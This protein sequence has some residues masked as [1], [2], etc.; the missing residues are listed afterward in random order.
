MNYYIGV[1]VGTS[2]TKAVLFD[3][4]G[5][6]IT[7][8]SYEYDIIVPKPGYAEQDPKKWLSATIS[9]LNDLSKVVDKNDIKGIGLSGQMHGLVMLD[10]DDNILYNAIIW[11]DNRTSNEVL[12]IE[13]F[14]KEKIREITG[15]YPMPAFTLAKLLWIKNNMPYIYNNIAKIMLPK[16][17]IRYMLTGEFKTEYSDAS[18]MQMMDLKNHCWSKEILDF[19]EIDESILPS[20]CESAE[21]TG[22]INNK[23]CL[24]SNKTFVVG[25]AGDQAAG[26]I[27]NGIVCEGEL[28]IALGSSGVVFSPISKLEL[29]NSSLQY[30]HHAIPNMY[31][32]MGVTNGCGNSLKWYKEELCKDLIEE[33]KKN[34]VNVYDYMTRNIDDIKA[35]SYGLI[36]LPYILG[37]RTPHLNTIATGSFIGLRS[38]TTKDMMT[39]S[40]IEGISYSMK[41][42]YNLI[43]TKIDKVLVN[44]GGAKN[45]K[46]CKI[47]ASMIKKDISR[48]IV[49]E[50]PALG[51]M[52]LAAIA[53][54]EY[55]DAIE[56]CSKII[57]V[58]DTFKPNL[59]DSQVYDEYYKI[60]QKCYEQNKIL[61]EMTERVMKK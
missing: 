47:L 32:I 1:D 12:E 59:E 54:G 17:Y 46:W 26:A 55:K 10:K 56:A 45:P 49:D 35:G 24:L 33:S 57:K 58:K 23:D 13:K 8:S 18:G 50:G 61:Y 15:N 16:D 36:Y 22:Y 37:E 6:Q 38:T 52:I 34:N 31:H 11:C 2:S 39:R 14:G 60:Y 30:F 29:N 20:F 43:D 3:K 28:S 25:G 5:N 41:D 42:C 19:F 9:S 40:V 7:S 51:V 53:G 27:G 48:N 21:I 4:E 44:G